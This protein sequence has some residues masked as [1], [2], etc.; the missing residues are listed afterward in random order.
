[1]KR[2][3]LA[4]MS[5]FALSAANA[6]IR[7]VNNNNPSPGQ[8]TD[9]QVAVNAAI[10]GDTIYVTGSPN[11]YSGTI[12][13]VKKLVI[14]GTGHSPQ[15]V[16][17]LISRVNNFSFDNKAASG[18]QIIG[19][20]LDWIIFSVDSVADVLIK[21]NKI[22]AAIS[23]DYTTTGLGANTGGGR[24]LRLTVESNYF[25][26]GGGP[27]FD[28]GYYSTYRDVYIRNNVFT[29]PL[30]GFQNSNNV[31]VTNNLF[32]GD[33]RLSYSYNVGLY[34][35]SN[36]FMRNGANFATNYGTTDNTTGCEWRYNLSYG[37]QT[38][39]LPN[40]GNAGGGNFGNKNGVDP[41]FTGF[42]S[43][44]SGPNNWDYIYD[45]TPA[46]ASPLKNAGNDGSDIGPT[47]NPFVNY[48]KYG[49]PNIP[50]IRSFSIVSPANATVA[51]GSTLQVNI[52]S[53]IKK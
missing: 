27:D 50:Q 30:I 51:P 6:T 46:A 3:V 9:L 12:S 49:I 26:N 11:V 39:N 20:D 2:I 44:A 34:V 19:L 7:V 40:D 23:F 32:L 53:T 24:F 28:A 37:L 21:R 31:Y 10:A 45:F 41:Q 13:L 38:N 48:N 42:V 36:I 17:P 35:Q 14:I 8:Y 18:S 43:G 5:L 16:N 1:M 4:V 52:I 25:T 15:K 47:G 29:G 33:G 22:R